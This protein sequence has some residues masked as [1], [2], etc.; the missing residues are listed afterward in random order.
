M[1][2]EKNPLEKWPSSRIPSRE[3]NKN[4]NNDTRTQ[5]YDEYIKEH[6]DLND[7]YNSD[8]NKFT[9]SY[10]ILAG[11]PDDRYLPDEFEDEEKDEDDEEED[12]DNGK[13]DKKDEEG[14][15]DKEDEEYGIN[16]YD[17]NEYDDNDPKISDIKD[18][19]SFSD[20]NYLNKE[21]M[22][23]GVD[24]DGM[25]A[26]QPYDKGQS[27]DRLIRDAKKASLKSSLYKKS[28]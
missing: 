5:H 2:R 23:Y 9:N 8:N 10:D 14:E 24:D 18:D 12:I 13:E 27:S 15:N 26:K 3:I 1:G 25:R 6:E 19:D 28:A 17:V 7:P 16:E 4:L 20:D 22:R 11:I 21:G